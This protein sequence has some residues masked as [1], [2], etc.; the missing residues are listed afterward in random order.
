MKKLAVAALFF[1]SLFATSVNITFAKT[2][3]GG[4][5][6]VDIEVLTE[7]VK[8]GDPVIV[9]LTLSDSDGV[10]DGQISLR[11]TD[12]KYFAHTQNKKVK[13]NKDG[14]Y[15][16]DLYTYPLDEKA[17]NNEWEVYSIVAFDKNGKYTQYTINDI[18]IELNKN[19]KIKSDENFVDTSREYKEL[20]TVKNTVIRKDFRIMYE[21]RIQEADINLNNI[22]VLDEE[23]NS[24]EI[25]VSPIKVK[26]QTMGI[27]VK[28]RVKYDEKS[29]Y[30]LY[31]KDI[32]NSKSEFMDNYKLEFTTK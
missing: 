31:I 8:P 25:K 3:D 27:S 15:V 28:P 9:R 26:G 24:V 20:S 19:L 30:T 23:G 29:K 14:K 7:T 5:E 12:N 16:V 13:S 21:D 32:K 6:V 22:M 1:V 2:G 17:G 4:P 11:T 10:R 18:N